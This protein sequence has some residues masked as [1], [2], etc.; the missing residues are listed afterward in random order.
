MSHVLGL[1]V[2][3]T[4]T[5]A[6]LLDAEGTV[7][8]ASCPEYTFETPQPLWSEQDPQPLVGRR[9]RGDPGA[10]WRPAGLTGDDIEAVGLAGQMH[11]LVALD[12]HDDVL[13]P[14]I[15]WNDQRTEAECDEI[16]RDDR[17]GSP[18]RG[19]RQ[20]RAHRVH[21]AEAHVGPAPRARRLVG[22]RAHPAAE[23][24]RPAAA[25]GGPRRR[26]CRRRRHPA[27]RPGGARLVD[28]DRGRAGDRPGVAADDV[29]RTGRHRVDLGRGGGRDR[30][31]R[32]HAGGGGRRRSGRGRGRAW[33]RSSPVWCRSRSAPRGS[34][35]PRPTNR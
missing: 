20:R 26:S 12:R 14:A 24:P 7:H 6:V 18:D 16:R 25:D 32:G 19:H 13:R 1:D 22:D 11:G 27:V 10:C 30:S 29:R 21:R 28:R 34:C 17:P 3:T 4:A 5:K 8:V 9:G 23:G 15:L 33:E 31:A 2:S 35:S